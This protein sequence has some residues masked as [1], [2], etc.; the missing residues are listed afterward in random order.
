M[1]PA[2]FGDDRGFFREL[3]RRSEF[4]AAGI[5]QFVQDNESSSQLA[6]LRGLHYQLEPYAQGKLVRAVRGRVWDV[7]VDFRRGSDTFLQWIGVELD[8]E[9]SNMLWLPPGFGHGFV[10][11]TDPAV[12]HYRATAEYH[13][14]SDR[15][16][17]FDDPEIDIKW[18]DVGG[19]FIVSEKDRLAPRVADAELF[20]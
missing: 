19:D 1:L 9:K 7:A 4:E 16:V 2:M 3:G 14:D 20:P 17:A 8:A 6:V 15:T 13:A 18:P 5:P 10:A 11:L 12:I